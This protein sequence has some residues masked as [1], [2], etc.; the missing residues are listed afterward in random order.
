MPFE[1]FLLKNVKRET[2]RHFPLLVAGFVFQYKKS[3]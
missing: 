1:A 3:C 2:E